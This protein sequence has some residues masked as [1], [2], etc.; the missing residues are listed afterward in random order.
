MADAQNS[1]M[2]SELA[3]LNAMQAFRSARDSGDLE[4]AAAA[5]EAWRQ[6]VRDELKSGSG[7]DS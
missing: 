6:L 7:K 1:E 5:E 3:F 2:D 4:A